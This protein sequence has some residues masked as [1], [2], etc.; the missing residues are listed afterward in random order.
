MPSRT[1]LIALTLVIAAAVVV[2]LPAR[3][4]AATPCWKAVINDWYDNGR[5]D[6]TY[7]I[8]CYREALSRLP[9]DV[10]DYTSLADDI[11]AAMQAALHQEGARTPQAAGG[12]TAGGSSGERARHIQAQPSKALF[13]SAIDKL[14]PRKADSVP[15]PLIVLAA[16]GGLLLSAAAAGTARRKLRARRAPPNGT[17]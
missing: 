12:D 1:S 6:N 16:L 3:A 13:R 7:P 14:G 9:E 17:D 5:I 10:L 4:S 8:H 11:S 2:A 15:L